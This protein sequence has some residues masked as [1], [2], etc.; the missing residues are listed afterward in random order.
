MRRIVLLLLWAVAGTVAFAQSADSLARKYLN[1]SDWFRLQRIYRT[2]SSKMSPLIRC[3]SSAMTAQFFNRPAEANASMRELLKVHQEDIGWG[4]V[5]SVM[6][7]MGRN[8]SRMGQNKEAGRLLRN[9]MAQLQGN[10]DEKV[11]ASLAAQAERYEALSG[12][13]TNHLTNL[14]EDYHVDFGLRQVA[15]SG[16]SLMFVKAKINGKTDDMVFDTGAGYN[17]ITPRLAQM[18]GL[19]F[20]NIGITAEGTRTIQGELAIAEEFV[21]GDIVLENVP[22]VVLD[23]TQGNE[24]AVKETSRLQLIMG[25]PFLQLFGKYTIDFVSRQ[26]HFVRNSPRQDVES[27]LVLTGSNVV[28]AKIVKDERMFPMIFDTG[29][30]TSFMAPEYY[31]AFSAEIARHG[32]WDIRGGLGFG[33]VVYN[34]VFVMPSVTIEAGG[35]RITMTDLPVIAISSE[36][37]VT[38]SGYGRLGLDFLKQ[39]DSVEVD[40]TNMTLH[41]R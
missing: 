39:C 32:K 10:A 37:N 16:Q 18:Y 38:G 11:G 20:L 6:T 21:V 24:K 33:G 22:F 3:F 35:K 23:V 29:A 40:N 7:M 36:Q 1:E 15:D 26:I 30:T 12:Y 4:N 27:N 14:R 19:K 2:D 17:V 41:L 9:F 5:L 8:L 34:S 13:Q 25:Q 28:Q 31:K